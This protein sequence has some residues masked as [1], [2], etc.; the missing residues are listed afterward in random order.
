MKITLKIAKTEKRN[1][2]ATVLFLFLFT[3]KDYP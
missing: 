2:F 1:K 3:D